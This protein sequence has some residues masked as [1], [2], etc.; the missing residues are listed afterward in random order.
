[1]SDEPSEEDIEQFVHAVA[2]QLAA[3]VPKSEIVDQLVDSGWDEDDAKQLVRDIGS[4]V[5]TTG[6]SGG[7][8]GMGWLMWIGILVGVNVL[9]YLFDWPFWLY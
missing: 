8:E 5:T 4:K 3:G 6:S 2:E 7:G 9:S 1:M